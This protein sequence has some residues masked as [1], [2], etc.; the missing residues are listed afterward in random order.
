MGDGRT[1]RKIEARYYGYLG[2]IAVIF[3]V[4]DLA[5]FGVTSEPGVSLQAEATNP[6]AVT[7]GCPE[8]VVDDTP[9]GPVACRL[10][11]LAQVLHVNAVP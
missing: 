2:R 5:S 1:D 11:D 3:G 10:K 6:G 4:L 9:S 7:G 8:M